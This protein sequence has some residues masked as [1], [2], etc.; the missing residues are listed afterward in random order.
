MEIRGIDVSRWQGDIDWTAAAGSGL[1]FA[2]IKACQGTKEDPKF[3]RNIEG[4]VKAG[5]YAGAYVYSL[6]EDA[7]TAG[8]EA[9]AVLKLVRPYELRWPVALD[10]EHAGFEK[11]P[12]ALR[13][14]VIDAF[15]GR[16]K[17][18]GRV[19]MIYSSSDWFR[20]VIPKAA[21]K[22][23]SV[24]LAR[25]RGDPPEEDFAYAMWQSGTGEIPGINGPTDLD[26]SFTDFSLY[27]VPT[28]EF[29]VTV[30]RKRGEAYLKMQ[31]A[32]NA[33]GYRDDSGAPLAEDGVWGKKSMQALLRLASRAASRENAEPQHGAQPAALTPDRRFE[34]RP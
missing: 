23:Y 19:P 21:I 1:R 4:A 17:A 6:A 2:M 12:K 3:K 32:L 15:C 27:T 24:W 28:A 20:R 9:E 31:E 10:L 25:W 7:E 16:I 26:V 33:S 5:I 11:L 14:R 34:R 18:A 29:A 22:R 30:P 13:L 8:A